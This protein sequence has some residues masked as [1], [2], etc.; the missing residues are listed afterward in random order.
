MNS[1]NNKKIVPLLLFVFT[2]MVSTKTLMAQS[3]IFFNNGA[4]VYAAPASILHLNGSFQNDNTIN[5]S[6][7]FENNGVMTIANSNTPGTVTLTNNSVLQGN[8]TYLV[9][10]DWINDATFIAANSTVNLNGN[11]PELITST[12]NTVTTFNNLV[13]TGTG[14]GNNR[15]KILQLVNA[16]IDLNGTLIIN[17]RELETG[18]NTLF[19][20]NPSPACIT[21]TTTPGS[22]GFVSSSFNAGGSGYLSRATNVA[23]GYLYPTGSSVGTTRYRPVLLTPAS[24]GNNT[25]TARLGNNNATIDGFSTTSL[26]TGMCAV[27]LLFYHEITRSAGNDNA[28]I[29]IFYDSSGDGLWAGMA[30]WNTPASAIW[31][32]MGTTIAST[33]SPF[34]S[35]EKISWSDFSNSPYILSKQKPPAPTLVCPSVCANSEGN[36]FSATG[37]DSIYNWTSP[38][39]T[40]IASGQGSNSVAIDWSI[41]SGTVSVTTASV[42][43][44]ESEPATCMV[45]V[46]NPLSADFTSL[47]LEN[48]FYNFSDLSSGGITSWQWDLGDGKSSS[49]QNPEHIYL[50]CGLHQICLTVSDG[51]CSDSSCTNMVVNE[52]AIIPNVFSPDGDGINDVFFINNTCLNDF[53]LEIYNRWGQKIFETSTGGWDGRTTSGNMASEGTYYFIFKGVSAITSTDYSTNGYLTLVRNE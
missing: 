46:S 50:T 35:I 51:F 41:L 17:D 12:N 3:T 42:P 18:T 20:L 14:T 40:T 10:Q 31:N 49:A 29:E 28:D 6:N 13:L 4:Q 39:G 22:E 43:G 38:A 11:L 33:G 48:H 7:V 34:N 23:S 25:Y 44:C 26:D 37:T 47:T 32:N 16:Q 19:V 36:I 9:E 15:K 1:K 24:S 8:G 45:S 30:Q 52:L 53:H 2:L 27:N 5:T 21:N